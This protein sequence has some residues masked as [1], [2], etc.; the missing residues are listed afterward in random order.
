M[1]RECSAAKIQIS[2]LLA[3]L[4]LAGTSIPAVAQSPDW[5]ADRAAC[6][7]LA[8]RGGGLF[9][10]YPSGLTPD[11]AARN[12]QIGNGQHYLRVNG[13]AIPY[14][15]SA[16]FF[17]IP[18]G[19]S[20]T[21][22]PGREAVWSVRTETVEPP[23]PPIG[24]D[25]RR[26]AAN[27]V[28]LWRPGIKTKCSARELPTFDALNSR[29]VGLQE[30]AQHHPIDPL[31]DLSRSPTLQ[32]LLHMKVNADCVSTDDVAISGPDRWAAYGFEKIPNDRTL[33]RTVFK[34]DANGSR[35]R[36]GVANSR[37]QQRAAYTKEFTIVTAERRAIAA[38]FGFSVPLP[39]ERSFFGFVGNGNDWRPFRTSIRIQR[40]DGDR[41]R[42]SG[43][44]ALNVSWKERAR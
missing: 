34:R 42:N 17:F 37:E 8:G 26:V 14:E 20:M 39:T 36:E 9:I 15:P 18:N 21:I 11:N 1:N 38:C 3:G 35:A 4:S 28:M 41:S 44:Q 30:Y 25:F 19:G 43:E 29:Y 32:T 16:R 27:A 7:Q 33:V 22:A 6:D 2:L 23:P 13:A 31:D 24:Q 12:G 5:N 10:V 40:V